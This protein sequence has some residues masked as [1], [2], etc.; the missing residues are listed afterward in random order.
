MK[1]YSEKRHTLL[2]R[3]IVILV[4]FTLILNVAHL[5]N[6]NKSC[7][8][9]MGDYFENQVISMHRTLEHR[10]ST[11]CQ[12]LDSYISDLTTQFPFINEALTN[13]D[14]SAL[15][16]ELQKGMKLVD[17]H[18]YVV[19][20][21][22]GNIKLSS[23]FGYSASE[24][25]ELK[26]FIRH[27]TMNKTSYSGFLQ[28]LNLG[29]CIVSAHIMKNSEGNDAAVIVG[30]EESFWDN[31]SLKTQ[32][33]FVNMTISVYDKDV[34]VASG[35]YDVKDVKVIGMKMPNAWVVDTCY[36]KKRLVSTIDSNGGAEYQSVFNPIIDYKG[37]VI[38]IIHGGLNVDVVTSLQKSITIDVLLIAIVISLILLIGVSYYLN[39]RLK[40]P[41]ANLV[42]VSRKIAQGN[43]SVD[44]GDDKNFDKEIFE[45]SESMKMMRNSLRNTLSAVIDSAHQLQNASKELSNASARLSEGANR[46]AASLEEISSSLEEMTG[47][48]HQNTDN[49]INTDNLMQT[50][51]QTIENIVVKANDSMN[52]AKQIATSLNEI[53]DLV[54]QTNIL[55]LNASVEAARAGAIGKG[56]GVIAKEVGRLAEQTRDTATD[57]NATASISMN[58][59]EEISTELDAILPNINKITNLVREITAA[60]KEQGIGVDQ[61]NMAIADLNNVTQ[62]TAANSEEVAANAENLESTAKQMLTIVKRF[63][64]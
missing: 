15:E 51:D 60:S 11:D 53:N 29:P 57:I 52:K 18:G 41:L 39:T 13:N 36:Q 48:I 2:F 54:N 40:K 46:Q 42:V 17:V 14:Y 27:L 21:I 19:T 23:Y 63:N 5:I 61:I 33:E 58:S 38:G 7:S 16:T 28:F 3:I 47:N 30:V 59:S 22:S 37:D 56:F 4:L 55:A 10:T 20:D 43:L 24:E 64:I 62:Q 12:W 35:A 49:S 44:M 25:Q 34:C 50:A 45:L 32:G 8:N 1:N 31:Q 26:R 6:I 9:I